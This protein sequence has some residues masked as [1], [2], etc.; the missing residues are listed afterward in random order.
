[1]RIVYRRSALNDLDRIGAHIASENSAAAERVISTIQKSVERLG[2]FPYSARKGDI[3]GT[4]E[5]V[6]TKYPYIVIYQVLKVVEVV[7]IFHGRQDW[8]KTVTNLQD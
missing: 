6:I 3:E 5:L 2:T 4:R 8:P 1:M 7:A